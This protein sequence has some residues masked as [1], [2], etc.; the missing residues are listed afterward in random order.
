MKALCLCLLWLPLTLCVQAAAPQIQTLIDFATESPRDW[1]S[2]A[3]PLRLSRQ[4][5]VPELLLNFRRDDR[6]LLLSRSLPLNLQD[7]TSFRF[8]VGITET[9]PLLEGSLAFLS[10]K[11]RYVYGFTLH[12]GGLNHLL[13][14]KADFQ[15]EGSPA[16][17]E[18]IDGI[19]FSFWPRRPGKT[20]LQP[21]R[22]E[23]VVD[24]LWVLDP[25]SLAGNGDEIYTSRISVRHCD[26]L[27]SSLGIPH[28]IVEAS[29]LRTAQTPALLLIPYL[30]ALPQETYQ[31]LN[32]LLRRG[33]RLIVFESA[34]QGLA[35]ALG[36]HLEERISSSTVG[37]FDHWACDQTI[38]PGAPSR[39]YQHAWE[40]RQIR[41]LE[42]SQIL[43]TWQDALGRSR[44][45]PAA[46]AAPAGIWSNVA[47]RSGD[48]PAKRILLAEW[49][50]QLAPELLQESVRYHRET[51]SPEQFEL[52]FGPIT[53]QVGAP[54]HLKSMARQS[55]AAGLQLSSSLREALRQHLKSEQLM[56]RAFAS[57]Q[58]VWDAQIKG[59][60]DQ[61]GTGIYAG[62]WDQTCRD[63]RAAGFNAV[64]PNMASAGRAHYPSRL[65]PPSKSLEKYGDQ[66]RAFTTAAHRH[67]LQAHAWKICWKLNTR[68]PAFQEKMRREGRLMQDAD[69]K[70]LP[71]LS[72]SH[73]ENVQFE[74]DS[75]LE[76]ARHAPLDG[77]HLDYMRYPGRE[78]DYGPAARRAFESRIGHPLPA[79][80]REVLGPLK[81]EYQRF[82]Q[83]ELHQ[84]MRRISQAL[85]KEFPELKLSV[86]VWGAWPDCADAQGQDWPVWCKEGLVDWIIPMNYTD[87]P[88]Q[89]A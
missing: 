81:E 14:S 52:R 83:Q 62:S 35:R 74:I 39:I 50:G 26:R 8:R 48:I 67:G 78:A 12:E 17:W 2:G 51:R 29:A 70:D 79:W 56:Q 65:L 5:G 28:A 89:F 53:D 1:K 21:L 63:L 43:A 9:E 47:W 24:Q 77:I 40:L 49:I 88:D 34:H 7:A 72:I 84:A 60:W 23:A 46:I 54:A 76:M 87:N 44:N 55:F 18:K 68:L 6:Q 45:E 31:Q 64:F 16:G 69:G 27:L 71:W 82:R 86:A 38:L 37:Q 61:N 75:L 73:P 42:N 80:P 25:E 3:E 58:P 36:V 66:L 22:L 4:D 10:G 85:K 32:Q 41:P 59:I 19:T 13:F 15:S 33:S 11:G 30:P 57:Q 20:R